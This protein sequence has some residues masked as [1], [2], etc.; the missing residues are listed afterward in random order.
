[1]KFVFRSYLIR[2]IPSH[3]AREQRADLF[4]FSARKV[5]RR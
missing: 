3:T 2:F 5:Q 4:F 1:M